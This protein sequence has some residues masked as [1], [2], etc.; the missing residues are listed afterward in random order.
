MIKMDDLDE[1]IVNLLTL[2]GRTSNREVAR[3]LDVSE[4]TVRNR[5]RRME[6]SG[7]VRLGAVVH[8]AVE[9]LG[10]SAFVRLETTP[11]A[12]RSV[13]QA[14]ARLEAVRFV[15]LMMGRYDVV[16]LVVT[17]DRNALSKIIHEHFRTWDGVTAIS[18]LEIV[19]TAKHRLD[20]IRVPPPPEAEGPMRTKGRT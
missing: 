20:L 10:C 11:A 19:G 12:A 14:A 7:A 5:L 13:A 9:N 4:G 17:E 1:Q 16:T 18:T 8:P 3:A 6:E 2:N 15:A